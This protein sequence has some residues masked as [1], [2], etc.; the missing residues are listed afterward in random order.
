MQVAAQSIGQPVRVLNVTSQEEFDAVF[1]DLG[2]E[3]IDALLVPNYT[4]FTNGRERL[5]A[6]AARY[7]VPTI[8]EYREFVDAGGLISYGSSNAQAYRQVGVYAGRVLKGENPADLPVMQPTKFEL[9]INLKAAK[10]IGLVISE[11]FLL[12]ADEVIE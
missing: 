6:L 3:R 8:Y 12:R 7:A 1:A 4:L 10:A 9:V 11:S 2:R 5:A